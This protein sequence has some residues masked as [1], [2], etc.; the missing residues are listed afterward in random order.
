MELSANQNMQSPMLMGAV[1]SGFWLIV[2][3]LLQNAPL[4]RAHAE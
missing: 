3:V 4:Q 1:A 2:R